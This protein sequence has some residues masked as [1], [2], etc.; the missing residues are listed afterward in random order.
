MIAK[1]QSNDKVRGPFSS[2][3]LS[4][5][6]L[7]ELLVACG[8][9]PS[10]CKRRS[11]SLLWFPYDIIEYKETYGRDWIYALYDQVTDDL[12]N[13]DF[14]VWI[15]ITPLDLYI[16]TSYPSGVLLIR[17]SDEITRVMII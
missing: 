11:L 1:Y 5:Q 10:L 17:H 12:T 8:K 13:K 15:P 9:R 4:H 14:I 2:E 16:K 6:P 7:K 3:W